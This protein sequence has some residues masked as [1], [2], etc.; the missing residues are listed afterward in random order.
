VKPFRAV[1]PA[2]ALAFMAAPVVAQDNAGAAADI[3]GEWG[4]ESI[5][6]DPVLGCDRS[7]TGDVFI[8]QTP[9]PAVYE[10]TMTARDYCPEVFDIRAEQTCVASR[11]GEKLVIESTIETVEPP[12]ALGT[13]WP[14]NFLLTI[15]DGANMV[16]TLDSAIVTSARFFR[17]LGPIA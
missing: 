3:L 9:D 15:I 10:C 5:F 14:D 8:S 1:L 4:F 2:L 11:D 17:R 16:G 13:Y 7:L 6:T 12:E